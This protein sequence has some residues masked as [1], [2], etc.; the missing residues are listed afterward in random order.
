MSTG[1]NIKTFSTFNTLKHRDENEM[2]ISK[3]TLEKN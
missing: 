1:E 3:G 2:P